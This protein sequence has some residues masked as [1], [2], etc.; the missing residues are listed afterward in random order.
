MSHTPRLRLSVAAVLLPLSL[1][2][3]ACG[4][5]DKDAA[6]PAAS[7]SGTTAGT[8]A[9][10]SASASDAGDTSDTE[11]SG[12]PITADEVAAIY[13]KAF[14]G[15]TSAK[16]SMTG[17]ISGQTFTATGE[18]DYT[19]GDPALSLT[20]DMAAAG[21]GSV[22][23]RLLDRSIYMKFDG[24]NGKWVVFDLGDPTGPLASMGNIME[25]FDPRSGLATLKKAFITG[26]YV[27][28]EDVAG[29]P[30]KKYTFTLDTLAS[31]GD[32]PGMTPQVRKQLPKTSDQTVW[33]GEDGRIAK[34]VS[35]FSGQEVT[36]TY[37]D[38][39]T[40]VDITAP[41]KNEVTDLSKVAAG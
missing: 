36:I 30:T 7:A 17:G 26:S 24:T 8:E 20:M 22:D 1:G 5:D 29:Q 35:G 16:L 21:L 38:W 12:T 41:P 31:I 27:G 25:Q 4:G 18:G 10:P 34:V 39:G 28:E 19:S 40:D 23:M 9:S 11:A 37:S 33:I 15:A 13:A 32:L 3:V 14:D 6:D 2:L